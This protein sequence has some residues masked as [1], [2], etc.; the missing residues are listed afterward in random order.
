MKNIIFALCK[1]LHNR[2]TRLAAPVSHSDHYTVACEKMGLSIGLASLHCF[3]V[4]TTVKSS[5]LRPV[6]NVVWIPPGLCPG[7]NSFHFVYSA[8]F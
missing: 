3:L 1:T 2:T 4:T 6:K 7:T 8:S 5:L